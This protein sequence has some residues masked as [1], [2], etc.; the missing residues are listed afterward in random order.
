[1]PGTLGSDSL[2]RP[3]FRFRLPGMRRT[4]QRLLP[5][6]LLL[7]GLS[8]GIGTTAAAQK[9]KLRALG[10]LRDVPSEDVAAR[11]ERHRRIQ[12]RRAGPMVIVHRGA[13]A[14]APENTL[15]AYAAAMDYGADGCEMDLRRT[16]DGEIVLFHDD[17]L[18]ELTDQ[19]GTVNR[20]NYVELLLAKPTFLYGTAKA[21]TRPPTFAA[22]LALAQQRA[23]L[24][25]LD[26]KEKG[27]EDQIAFMLD[28]ADA[29]DHVIGVNMETAAR[30]AS[31]PK[32]SLPRYKGPGL[33]DKRQDVDPEAVRA[34][35]AKPGQ[36]IMVND[37]RVAAQVLGRKPYQ[38]VPLPDH[39]REP[40]EG[41]PVRIQAALDWKDPLDWIRTDHYSPAQLNAGPLPERTHADGSESYG[42]DRTRRILQRARAAITAGEAGKKSPELVRRLVDQLQHRTLHKDWMFHG[43]DGAMAVRAL[44]M[45]HAAET[46][47]A[48][49]KALKAVDPKLKTVANPEWKS[50]PLGWTDFRVKMY[51]FPALGEMRCLASKQL[52]QEYLRMDEAKA[53]EI[54][55]LQYEEATSALLKQ[56]L[57]QVELEALL[58]SL[59][60]DV[61]GTAILHCLD[62][63]TPARTAALKAAAPWALTLAAV[64]Q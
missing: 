46:V 57:S 11:V 26:V 52:L 23:M 22:V 61:R 21:D 42:R 15:E 8:T 49:G 48:L 27:L 53:R 31:N 63:P 6:S 17:M 10:Y 38:P 50:N 28:A 60:S 12:E 34:Q 54:A 64:K 9:P 5:V 56:D 33:Y 59:R 1:M 45:L 13:T 29:W 37:P 4:V 2:S 32:I 3:P 39:L 19:F 25:H 35:L 36:M 55:P 40:R 7:L 51:V 18:D 41:D 20:L 47:P 14:I 62:H 43:L 30:L 58:R 24:L 16:R 44:G